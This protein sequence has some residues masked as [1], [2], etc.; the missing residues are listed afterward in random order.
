MLKDSSGFVYILIDL[1]RTINENVGWEKRFQ[2][3]SNVHVYMH[4]DATHNIDGGDYVHFPNHTNIF[5][6]FM[7]AKIECCIL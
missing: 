2:K 6:V 5:I 7:Y 4:V 3:L 1:R